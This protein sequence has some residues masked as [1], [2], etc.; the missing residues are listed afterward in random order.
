MSNN[1]NEEPDMKR[2]RTNDSSMS[3]GIDS[4]SNDI[5]IRFASYLCP[6]DLV[7]LALTCRRF[8]S[9]N[10]DGLSLVG[11][12][13]QQIISDAQQ[14]E[15]EALPK[16]ADQSYIELY[17]E[18]E[19][20][21][22]P[23]VFDQLIGGAVSYVADDNKSH[24]KFD[25]EYLDS[26]TAICNHVMRAGRHYVTFTREGNHADPVHRGIRFGI[27]RPLPNWD[28]NGMQAF[29]PIHEEYFNELLQ[30]RTD[31][32]GDSN[33]HYC[34]TS[35][36]GRC[37]WQDWSSYDYKQAVPWD[38]MEEVSFVSGDKIG[39][40]LDLN[41]GTLSMYKNGRR[42]GTAKDGLA[43]EYC[44]TTS[45]WTHSISATIEKGSVPTD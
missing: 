16:M 2:R 41:A 45:S 33:V 34:S 36:R 15:R 42:L 27:I 14:D 13:V 5:A 10:V 37:I 9:K 25:V 1:K 22:G 31:R 26:S 7:N 35:G 3:I 44:W 43:G 23:R 18:L 39:M 19:K 29:D 21:R 6:R 17:V 20:Y 30:E 28:K 8:G 24:V 38:G 40:L 4:F 11:Y 12:T 32:W